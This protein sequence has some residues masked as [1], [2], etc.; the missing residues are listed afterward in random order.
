[1]VKKSIKS[2]VTY[3]EDHQVRYI[4]IHRNI[5]GDSIA[6]FGLDE[7]GRAYLGSYNVNKVDIDDLKDI[8]EYIRGFDFVKG[9][10]VL[11]KNPDEIKE[12]Y[13]EQEDVSEG[14]DFSHAW[15]KVDM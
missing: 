10:L 15:N 12:I 14:I 11:D 6:T 3:G 9:I 5:F 13:E 1:M 2:K 8:Y 4:F 7:E